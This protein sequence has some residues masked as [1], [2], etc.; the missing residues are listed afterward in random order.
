MTYIQKMLRA[1][2]NEATHAAAVCQFSRTQLDDLC[3]RIAAHTAQGIA[4]SEPEPE[5]GHDD[6]TVPVDTAELVRRL[7]VSAR[8]RRAPAV[9]SSRMSNR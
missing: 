9:N 5:V 6:D 4:Q 8:A 3:D 7:R 2:A 1:A